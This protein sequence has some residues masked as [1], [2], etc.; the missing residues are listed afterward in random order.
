MKVRSVLL[1]LLLLGALAAG[2]YAWKPEA[3]TVP[4]EIPLAG[5]DPGVAEAVRDALQV[6]NKK[7]RSGAAW[8]KLGM[9]LDA[10]GFE[11]LAPQCYA[12]AARLDPADPAW[13]YLN[14]MNR[15]ELEPKAAM[16][17]LVKALALA[18]DG[19]EKA[20]I[21]F[22]L[23]LVLIEEGQLAEAD[24][25]LQAV[26]QADPAGPRVQFL[27]GLLA[28][29]RDD[30]ESARK[31]L[32]T[33]IEAPNIQKCASTLLAGLVEDK[34]E[35]R[36]LQERAEKLPTDQAWPDPFMYEMKGN[37]VNRMRRITPF[38]M[39]DSQGRHEEALAYLRKLVAEAPDG[40]VC[41]TL[42]L[43]LFKA[44]RFEDAEP[45]FKAALRYE[46]TNV[47]SQ[48]LIGSCYLHWGEKKH[49]E[50]GGKEAALELF[51]QAVIAADQALVLKSELAIAHQIRG[52]ALKY[53]GRTDEAIAALRQSVLIQPEASDTHLELGE[54]FVEKGQMKEAIEH[55]Q[56]AVRFARSGDQRAVQALDKA[57]A[58]A[59]TAP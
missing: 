33:L 36:K 48:F 30:R 29:A 8:G 14:G 32:S 1:G 31:H 7:P 47:K 44:G 27:L 53:L 41:Y 18:S 10:N 42:G 9:V 26:R 52:S 3:A 56:N 20:A 13:P 23:A 28:L 16:P 55:L 22:R 34:D 57:R 40:E 11:T 37:Y 2:W 21:H 58:R 17:L 39:L 6:V 43:A 24:R 46:P 15:L 35:A 54:L 49:Q 38:T 59:K 19:V 51:R 50:P 4:P 12:E 25:H 45:M 5:V